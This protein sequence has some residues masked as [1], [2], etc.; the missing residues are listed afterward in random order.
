MEKRLLL[1]L[2]V[3]FIYLPSISQNKLYEDIDY[4]TN[5]IKTVYAG[6]EAK[7]VGN[8]FDKL[9]Q[10]VKN[11]NIKDTFALLSELTYFF[12]EQHLVL[13][14][15]NIAKKPIDTVKCKADSSMIVE[16]FRSNKKKD[17]Y[18]GYWLSEYG[19]FVMAIKKISD[20]PITYNG[21][22]VE[23]KAKTKIGFCFLKLTLQKDG[24]YLTDY[25]DESLAYRIFVRARFKNLN[26]LWLNSYGKWMRITNYQ[27]GILADVK[28]FTYKLSCTSLDEKTV[29]IKMSNFGA[30]NVK[31]Y[32]SMIK[33][34]E[35]II[36]QANTLIL[37]TRN[38]MGGSARNYF[39]LLPYIYTTSIV[40][41]GGYELCS[42]ELINYYENNLKQA[43]SVNDSTRIARLTKKLSS[44]K[45]NK[46]KF[47]YILPDT[48]AKSLPVLER[49]K[50]V[51]IIVN[52]NCLSAAELMLLD[53]KQ[54]AKTTIFG[55]RTGGAVDYLDGIEFDL[56]ISKYNLFIATTKRALTSKEPSF[57]ATGIKPDVEIDDSVTDWVTFV[58]K[59]YD[60]HK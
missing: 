47:L 12:N 17:K 4:L 32:D 25:T 18:E 10:K 26:T 51:A 36:S 38:N 40:H 42:E 57:D 30:Y 6:Y 28:T 13:T 37:D 44:A 34:N 20:K 52:N 2:L 59:Y 53:F 27:P 39:P 1:L 21:Y 19:N 50:N 45:Q 3:T 54:S 22:V 14:D 60:E 43:I 46:G 29:L 7:K 11:S 41:C 58:K 48:I 55:E 16:Y 23:T 33:A 31:R 49:P 9:I 8:K 24:S 15:F 35:K 56:P 5:K